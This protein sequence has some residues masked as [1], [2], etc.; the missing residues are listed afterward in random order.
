MADLS[1]LYTE[2]G[3]ALHMA[4]TVEYNIV[5]AHL[6]LARTGFSKSR[7]EREDY[8]SKK[9]LGALLKPAIDSGYLDENCMLFIQTVVSARNHLAHSFFISDADVHTQD[10]VAFLLREVEKMID[11]FGRAQVLFEQVL[12]ALARP[13]GI[14][15]DKVKAEARVLVLQR[16]T[17]ESG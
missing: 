4:Q 6:L 8:W 14:D 12:N 13:H 3:R 7:E 2:M 5:S 11:I 16:P 9:T 10:G 17:G 15:L 1:H